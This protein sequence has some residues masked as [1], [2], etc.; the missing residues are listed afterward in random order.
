MEG[1]WGLQGVMGEIVEILLENYW[2]SDSFGV[3]FEGRKWD[4]TCRKF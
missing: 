2:F 3:D 1:L 4:G